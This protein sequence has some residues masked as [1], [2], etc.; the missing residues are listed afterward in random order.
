MGPWTFTCYSGFIMVWGSS[1]D[2]WDQQGLQGKHGPQKGWGASLNPGNTSHPGHPAAQRQGGWAACR[3]L[4]L[5]KLRSPHH[6]CHNCCISSSTYLHYWPTNWVFYLSITCLL[7]IAALEATVCHIV[8]VCSPPPP[9]QLHMLML[10]ATSHWSG[11]RSLVSDTPSIL[12]RCR[13]SF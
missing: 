12:D 5:C 8:C 11:S 10:T 1:T 6:T 7:V 2:H 3:G 9:K 4:S 13:D